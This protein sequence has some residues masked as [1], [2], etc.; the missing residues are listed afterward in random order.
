[1]KNK[2]IRFVHFLIDE[3]FNEYIVR[4]FE[5]V[6]VGRHRYVVYCKQELPSLEKFT[7]LG[8][9]IEFLNKEECICL[10]SEYEYIVFHCATDENLYLINQLSKRNISCLISWGP[11]RHNIKKLGTTPYEPITLSAYLEIAN[12]GISWSKKLR[13]QVL[14]LIPFS[15]TEYY[16]H[17]RTGKDHPDKMYRKA[18]AKLDYIS[19]ILA[20][21]FPILFKNAKGTYLDFSYG[22]IEQLVSG[23]H[24]KEPDLGGSI[25]VGHSGF[26]IN[27]QMDVLAKIKESGFDNTIVV[28]VSYGADDYNTV[29]NYAKC[30]FSK[31][32]MFPEY[33]SKE[34]YFELL[35]S[36]N[37][38]VLNNIVQQG[39]G[40][41]YT[42]LAF[43]H[44][45]FL[46]EKGLLYKYCLDNSLVVNSFQSDFSNV[47]AK[48]PLSKE[49]KKQ[50]R[51][52]VFKLIGHEVVK[53][54]T[55]SFIKKMVK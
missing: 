21:E 38:I 10:L 1:M 44:R 52:T 49:E 29:K 36:C 39:M 7:D 41:L 2:D 45:I 47:L 42:A 46:N 37:S 4:R 28:P 54:R 9:K 50:N 19:T 22:T 27:N 43:G 24:E 53:K 51:L 40:N 55:H 20:D 17:L 15:F 11:D 32:L 5:E 12:K 34:S 35:K 33:M 25:L 14:K 6:G 26:L 48:K 31:D 16:Y 8:R 18:I 23:F 30:L 3:K 13:K